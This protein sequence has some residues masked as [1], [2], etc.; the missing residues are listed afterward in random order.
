MTW[1]KKRELW[2]KVM[3]MWKDSGGIDNLFEEN[4]VCDRLYIRISNAQHRLL[5]RLGLQ[6]S[7]DMDEILNCEDE[8]C[9]RVA[10]RMFDYGVEYAKKETRASDSTKI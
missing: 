9:M 8:I 6:E 2:E 5:E 1:A 3:G 7:H 4:K 10:I